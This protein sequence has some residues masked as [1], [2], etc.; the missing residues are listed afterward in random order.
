M[1]DK[2]G[3]LLDETIEYTV[4]MNSYVATTYRF[5]H[6]DPGITSSTTTAQALTGYLTEVKK[7]NYS[8]VQRTSV[9]KISQ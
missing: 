3:N 6:R 1:F 5:D 7:V 2:S 9:K 8:G 4:G